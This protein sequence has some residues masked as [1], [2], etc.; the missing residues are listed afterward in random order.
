MRLPTSLRLSLLLLAASALLTGAARAQ[1]ADLAGSSDHPLVGRYEGSVITFHETKAYEELALPF[2]PLERGEK[3]KPEAWQIP[4]A[5]KLTSIRYEGPAD[6]SILE[7][8]R[9]YEASL[10]SQGFQ[11]DFFCNGAD[12]CSPGRSIPTFWEAGNGAIGMPT[13][14]NTSVYLLATHDRPEGRVTV[15]MLGV[16]TRATSS[17]PLTPYVAVTVVEA[18]PMETDKVQVVEAG[19]LERTLV[20]DGRIA[21]YGIYF[22]FDKAEI[23]PES[24]PQLE[25][26]VA[27]LKNNPAMNVLI[28]GHTDDQG[29]FDYNLSL[30]QKRAQAVVDTLATKHGVARSRLIPAGAGMVAPIAS[31]RTEEGRARNRRVEIV[32]R[33]S[34]G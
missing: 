11:I 16:E 17:R 15:G 10:K 26:L 19:E 5:G 30:S 31:N 21:I 9:N 7:V 23:K 12:K 33:Y 22:D 3:D 32:E 27:F 25:Q 4:L 14:W 8:M 13:T 29:A 34:G 20:R 6:R 28:V 24:A 1:L 2:K 18:K